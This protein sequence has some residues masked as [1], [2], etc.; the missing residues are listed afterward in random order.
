MKAFDW[1]MI[2]TVVLFTLNATGLHPYPTWVICLPAF[3]SLGIALLVAIAQEFM[4]G[5][6]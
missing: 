6:S 4:N 5:K 1:V 2:W 3:G